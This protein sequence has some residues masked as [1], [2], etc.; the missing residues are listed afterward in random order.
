MNTLSPQSNPNGAEQRL[1]AGTSRLVNVDS[2]RVQYPEILV[3]DRDGLEANAPSI[4]A[5]GGSEDA[6]STAAVVPS[7]SRAEQ[8]QPPS[9]RQHTFSM[10]DHT[11]Q[12]EA[13]LSSS[14]SE[15]PISPP[16]ASSLHS[17]AP[18]APIGQRDHHEI[19]RPA[20]QSS[21]FRLPIELRNSIYRFIVVSPLS[22]SLRASLC[23][24]ICVDQAMFRIGYFQRDTVLPLLLIC[25]QIH[26]EASTILYA[27]NVFVFHVST[28][29]ELP[30]PFFNVS[31]AYLRCVRRAYLRTEIF[32]TPPLALLEPSLSLRALQGRADPSVPDEMRCR[33]EH[34]HSIEIE[35]SNIAASQAVPAES[36]IL[37]D[38]EGTID[39][40]AADWPWKLQRDPGL[41]YQ[42]EWWS[43]SCQMW[44]M[45][46]LEHDETSVRQVFRR[47]TWTR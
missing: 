14:E 43:S 3:A 4:N 30:I 10:S 16:H 18:S 39:L 22:Q 29:G 34:C 17:V 19:F 6:S 44:K 12:D 25:R 32:L 26:L 31:P 9:A 38:L 2:A 42:D 47:I 46:L 33:S 8:L 24:P 7:T 11:E 1:N 23:R 27:E 41:L 5:S 45:M 28:L 13:N 37:V 35:C 15:I 40:P 20:P 21:F 36:G